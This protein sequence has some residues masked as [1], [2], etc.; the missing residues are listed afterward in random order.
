[1][2]PGLFL[3]H[4]QSEFPELAEDALHGALGQQAIL[5]NGPYRWPDAF[6]VVLGTLRQTEGDNF[7]VDAVEDPIAHMTEEDC[8]HGA[9]SALRRWD[10]RCEKHNDRVERLTVPPSS[11]TKGR[12]R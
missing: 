4:E 7:V 6:T 3:K 2:L 12:W 1:M 9:A 10:T 11:N 8:A 5:G